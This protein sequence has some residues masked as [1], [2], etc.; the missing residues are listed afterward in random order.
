VSSEIPWWRLGASMVVSQSRTCMLTTRE[1]KRIVVKYPKTISA[2]PTSPFQSPRQAPTNPQAY[3]NPKPANP[4]IE[5]E[6]CVLTVSHQRF[7]AVT[8]SLPVALR[9]DA[10]NE[11]YSVCSVDGLEQPSK[12]S[13]V[14]PRIFFQGV[15]GG[16][17]FLRCCP[18]FVFVSGVRVPESR[19]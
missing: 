18:L 5:S 11:Q 15:V 19:R 4:S 6:L 8:Q 17:T 3:L 1:R 7:S 12:S 13:C 9:F 10:C 2:K 14:Y 16:L